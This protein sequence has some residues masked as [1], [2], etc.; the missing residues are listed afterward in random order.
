MVQL[1]LPVSMKQIL[2]HIEAVRLQWKSLKAP[3][4]AVEKLQTK[5]WGRSELPSI[6]PVSISIHSIQLPART[7]SSVKKEKQNHIAL[8]ITQNKGKGFQGKLM[9]ISEFQIYLSNAYSLLFTIILLLYII[10]DKSK[11]CIMMSLG[12][13][14]PER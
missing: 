10:P 2:F 3:T 4:E 9:L 6:W 12:S 1:L 5:I 7:L 11:I 13:K 8:E 14:W